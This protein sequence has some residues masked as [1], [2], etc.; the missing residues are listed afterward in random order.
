MHQRECQGNK[1]TFIP[2]KSE[3]EG[4]QG[5][6]LRT[7]GT[8]WPHPSLDGEVDP[9]SRDH[10]EHNQTDILTSGVTSLPPSRRRS[11][12]AGQ[13]LVGVCS[14]LQWRNRPRFSRGSL[15]PGCVRDERIVH[16]FSKNELLL[17]LRC[18]ACKLKLA[19]L[20]KWSG[21]TTASSI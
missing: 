19:F 14:P 2:D 6:L 12:R 15:T 4:I 1:K 7:R 16:P 8:G 20:L 3:N 18:D 13:W 9:V 21:Q 17:R 10:D 5:I 11:L